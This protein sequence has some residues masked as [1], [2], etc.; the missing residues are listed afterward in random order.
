MSEEAKKAIIELLEKNSAKGKKK[1]YPKDLTKA[2][3]TLPRADVKAG[4]QALLD[5]GILAY[6]SSGSTTYVMLKKDY[7]EIKE[8][9]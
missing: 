3:D 5:E 8:G 1:I 2:L 6:W 9:E 7:D 4:I